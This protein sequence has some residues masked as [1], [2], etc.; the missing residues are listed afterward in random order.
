M[1]PLNLVNYTQ[2]QDAGLRLKQDEIFKPGKVTLSDALVKLGGCTGSFVSKD[3]LII[4]NH[5]CV[6]GGVA[7]L[8]TT[9]Q[10]YLENGFVAKTKES[11]LPLGS[12]CRITV[13]YKDVSSI[14]LK[15]VS[16]DLNAQEKANTIKKNTDELLV[17]EREATPELEVQISTM[18]V[19]RS[20]ML[21]RYILLEDVRLVVAPPKQLVN[22]AEIPI[23][24]NGQDMVETLVLLEHM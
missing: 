10:N 2:L 21:F 16:D 8:S 20:Y 1:F 7:S 14:V 3:G 5:H 9:D 11:E 22:L 6:Y 17:S 15:G 19:G 18:F 24:G 12:P 4:T 13:G 23:I